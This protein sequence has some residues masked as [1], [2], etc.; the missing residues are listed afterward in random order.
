LLRQAFEVTAGS[1]AHRRHRRQELVERERS[2]DAPAE[3]GGVHEAVLHRHWS[4]LVDQAVLRLH[5]EVLPLRDPAVDGIA[6]LEVALLVELHQRDARDRLRH[7]E[8]AVDRVVRCRLV[9][10]AVHETEVLEVTDHAVAGDG[11]LAA[12]DLA[13]L[14]VAR[15]QMCVD[16]GELLGV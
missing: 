6:E 3:P 15:L 16:V 1:A 5:L 10:L 4:R 2:L 14:D 12:R 13:G 8:Q 7:R 11:D 9:R